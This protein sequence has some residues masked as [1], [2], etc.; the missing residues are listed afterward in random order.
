M[1]SL[2]CSI[3]KGDQP[4][5][6]TWLLNGKKISTGNGIM[7][8][9]V[10]KRLNTLSIEQVRA[11]HAGNYSCLVRNPAGVTSFSA[12]LHVN[13]STECSIVLLMLT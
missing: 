2:T 6:V 13:G 5:N 9:K 12:V 8:N 11:E 7:I 10:N 1:V 4:L 3:N